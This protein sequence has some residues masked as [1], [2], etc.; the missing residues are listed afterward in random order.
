MKLTSTHSCLLIRVGQISHFNIFHDFI[1]CTKDT[2]DRKKIRWVP[3]T[4]FFTDLFLSFHKSV[5]ENSRIFSSL[6]CSGWRLTC[7]SWIITTKKKSHTMR[8]ADDQHPAHS[9]LLCSWM[10]SKML[11][12]T[13]LIITSSLKSYAF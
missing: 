8:E 6:K 2:G 4:D 12:E 13:L 7:L 10:I 5:R 9:Y 11:K 1:K 3:L